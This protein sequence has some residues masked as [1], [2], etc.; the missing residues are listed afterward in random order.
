[1]HSQKILQKKSR[2]YRFIPDPTSPQAAVPARQGQSLPFPPSQQAPAVQG[3][4]SQQPIKPLSSNSVQAAPTKSCSSCSIPTTTTQ[5]PRITDFANVARDPLPSSVL[6]T[7][8]ASRPVY[9]QAADGYQNF[10]Q[11]QPAAQ[12]GSSGSPNYPQAAGGVP[13]YPQRGQNTPQQGVNYSQ[14]GQAAPQPGPNYQQQGQNYPQQGQNSPLGG[15]NSPQARPNYPQSEPNYPQAGQ[16]Y[17]QAGQNSPQQGQNYPQLEQNSPALQNPQQNLQPPH[18]DRNPKL[19]ESRFGE[20]EEQNTPVGPGPAK[21]QL[22]SAQMQIVDKNTDVNYKAPG[23]KDG[24]PDGLTKDD[25][26]TLLYTFNY[27]VGFHGHHEEGYTN[28]AKKGYYYV[29]GRNGVRTRVDYVA[30]E[31]GFRPK[32]TQ[33]VLD[34]LSEDVPKPETEKDEKYGLKGY[35]F[36]WLYYPV[37][38]KKL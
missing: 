20:P 28:G 6:G 30:D 32:I 15:Q 38:S 11:K 1:M 35:E 23:E 7:N 27:T 10:P 21:P 26:M 37:E 17:P 14:Q 31:N 36:K 12:G 19:I 3:P 2:Y 16:N 4:S 5:A 34:L 33:E 29:T 8:P 24:L 22:I 13:N 9:P 18:G 25:M